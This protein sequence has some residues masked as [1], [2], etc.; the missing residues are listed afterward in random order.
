M[1]SLPFDFNSELTLLEQS[2]AISCLIIF[3]TPKA[4]HGKAFLSFNTVRARRLDV[5]FDLAI[6][7]PYGF[8]EGVKTNFLLPLGK[9]IPTY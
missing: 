2:F 7:R 1:L 4:T 3:A 6:I 5:F 9:P 8:L